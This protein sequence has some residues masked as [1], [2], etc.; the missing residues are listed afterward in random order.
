MDSLR[1]PTPQG[2][3]QA[4]LSPLKHRLVFNMFNYYR[5]LHMQIWKNLEGDIGQ[6]FPPFKYR[7]NEQDF[8]KCF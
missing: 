2:P 6:Y 4:R 7:T 3:E 8:F 5:K 1:N